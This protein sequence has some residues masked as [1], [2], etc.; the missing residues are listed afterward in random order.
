MS[1]VTNTAVW[2]EAIEKDLVKKVLA[3]AAPGEPIESDSQDLR[4][5]PR[6]AGARCGR[7]ELRSRS[8]TRSVYR[9]GRLAGYREPADRL[10]LSPQACRTSRRR[11]PPCRRVIPGC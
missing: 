9:S 8:L 4:E 7:G 6:A 1:E 5:A 11:W 2:S 10:T 3:Q